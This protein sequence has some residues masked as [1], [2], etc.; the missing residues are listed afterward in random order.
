MGQDYRRRNEHTEQ[1]IDV[2]RAKEIAQGGGKHEMLYALEHVRGAGAEEFK[3]TLIRK[4]SNNFSSD[5]E[6]IKIVEQHTKFI[7]QH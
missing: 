3:T 5:P 4:L 2:E 1:V 6:V 7:A